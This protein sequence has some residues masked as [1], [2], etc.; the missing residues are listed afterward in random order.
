MT[1][2]LKIF[3]T[4]MMEMMTLKMVVN[5]NGDQLGVFEAK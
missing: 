3:L 4:A 2:C 1:V 5:I